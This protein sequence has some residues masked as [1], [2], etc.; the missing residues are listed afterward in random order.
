[1]P[2]SEALRRYGAS[3][4]L[5]GVGREHVSNHLQAQLGGRAQRS[6]LTMP[7]PHVAVSPGRHVMAH[8]AHAPTAGALHEAPVS[9]LSL[10]FFSAACAFLR[11]D[12][13]E[14]A[15]LLMTR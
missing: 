7:G 1:M 5:Q 12:S 10:S 14:S 13:V 2:A 6:P 11:E 4:L 15:G 3:E 9:F 8:E